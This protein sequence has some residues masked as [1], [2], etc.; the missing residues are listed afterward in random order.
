M[1]TINEEQKQPEITPYK[2]G[3]KSFEEKDAIFFFGREKEQKEIL[4]HFKASRLTVLY[5]DSGVGKTSLLQAGIVSYFKK[6]ARQNQNRNKTQNRSPRVAISVL[7]LEHCYR[8]LAKNQQNNKPQ[9]NLEEAL[10]YKIIEAVKECNQEES[11]TLDD[12]ENGPSLNFIEKLEALADKVEG[13]LFIILDQFEEYFRQENNY[14]KGNFKENFT[15]CM[16]IYGFPVHFLISIRSDQLY[17]LEK[18]FKEQIPTIL[19][20]CVILESLTEESAEKAIE[21]PIERYDFIQHIIHYPLTILS[22]KQYQGKSSFLENDLM[23]Y[24]N[25]NKDKLLINEVYC[26]SDNNIKEITTS[27]EQLNKESKKSIIIFKD[28]Y[29]YMNS[30]KNE[31]LNKLLEMIKNRKSQSKINVV[32][33]I[34][35][36]QQL[37]KLEEY[38]KK[39]EP[40]LNQ[41]NQGYFELSKNSIKY[42]KNGSDDFDPTKIQ[43]E[44]DIEFLRG[45]FSRKIDQ[46]LAPKIREII[47]TKPIIQN[48]TNFLNESYDSTQSKMQKGI[49]DQITRKKIENL[50]KID[51]IINNDDVDEIIKVL[52]V[53]NNVFDVF[54]NSNEIIK[55]INNLTNTK[56]IVADLMQLCVEN[57]SQINRNKI[58]E[59]MTNNIKEIMSNKILINLKHD[60]EEKV[61]FVNQYQSVFENLITE[62]IVKILY[63]GNKIPSPYLQLIMYTWW[64]NGKNY[65]NKKHSKDTEQNQKSN[66]QQIRINLCLGTLLESSFEIQL[67]KDTTSKNL[68]KQD[69]HE[70]KVKIKID[71][72]S[73]ILKE[74]WA[75]YS[76]EIAKNNLREETD[77]K[78]LEEIIQR[79]LQL[80]VKKSV[81]GILEEYL[82]EVIDEA[83]Y[84]LN[85]GDSEAKSEQNKSGADLTKFTTREEV[86]RF[87]HHLYAISRKQKEGKEE[88]ILN[89]INEETQTLKLPLPPLE[90]KRVHRYLDY[91]TEKRILQPVAVGSP[92]SIYYEIFFDALIPAIETYQQ[93]HLDYL[94]C[95]QKH[96]ELK[97]K[98]LACLRKNKGEIAAL[99]AKESYDYRNNK[100][101]EIETYKI[102]SKDNEEIKNLLISEAKVDECL[103]E[104]LKSPNFNSS[105]LELEEKGDWVDNRQSLQKCLRDFRQV[106]FSPDGSFL[107]ASNQNGN[108]GF[109]YLLRKDSKDSKDSLEFKP[110][111][112]G[113]KSINEKPA[114]DPKKIREGLFIDIAMTFINN[115]RFISVARDGEIKLW[116]IENSSNIELSRKLTEEKVTETFVS[117][118]F[119]KKKHLLAVGSWEGNIWLGNIQD[120]N[121]HSVFDKLP[122]CHDKT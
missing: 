2:E 117:V 53:F 96:Q 59:I 54:G 28:F 111:V 48:I 17:R 22:G 81:Q 45:E 91:C 97:V 120:L 21:K 78:A 115:D 68:K 5:G 55:N 60:Y 24:F 116:K 56:K 92:P 95:F 20:N 19:D 41:E 94:L 121:K 46:D 107:V 108:L 85:N 93:E 102:D 67:N 30:D 52:Y 39:L 61:L 109:C 26:V 37:E 75:N 38:Y 23:N 110:E 74:I 14:D 47:K 31:H 13:E 114:H 122:F 9:Q 58:E 84:Q 11:E 113:L 8:Q 100:L 15:R 29:K 103:R 82:K 7:N 49:N 27:L 10:L 87:T 4:S 89:Y 62:N 57:K 1:N 64:K 3:L 88:P 36:K 101:A 33:E 50:I 118:A 25:F 112:N 119:N 90:T 98:S 66:N 32:I 65:D 40:K 99:L 73:K 70:K 42:E 16:E 12:L 83:G 35:N 76:A 51:P 86:Y 77:N 104:V 63:Q 106:I 6:L 72:L 34:Q 69:K 79:Q 80:L 71:S 105:C 44:A 18:E 43:L